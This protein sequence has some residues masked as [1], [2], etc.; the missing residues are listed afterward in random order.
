[1]GLQ[2]LECGNSAVLNCPLVQR[3]KK[4][5]IVNSKRCNWS[6]GTISGTNIF[7]KSC[8]LSMWKRKILGSW[9]I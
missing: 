2:Q 8:S 6:L 9:C 7:P 1:M 4:W 5:R 3:I